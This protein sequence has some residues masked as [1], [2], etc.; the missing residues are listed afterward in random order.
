MST[1]TLAQPA[2]SATTVVEDALLAHGE[3]YRDES[4]HEVWRIRDTDGSIYADGIASDFDA[5]W[6][7]EQMVHA[8]TQR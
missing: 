6:L 3:L 2:P 5:Q 7:A 8:R 1:G 4:G